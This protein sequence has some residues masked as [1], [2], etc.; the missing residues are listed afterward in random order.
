MSKSK[1]ATETTVSPEKTLAEIQE[2]LKRYG[3]TRV[4]FIDDVEQV[5][6]VFEMRGRRVRFMMP[7]PD[8]ESTK[9]DSTGRYMGEK[10]AGEAH[11]KAVRQR[12]RALLLTI[13][14]KLESVESGIEQFEEAFLA[15]IVL[16][17]GQTMAEWAAPQIEAAYAGNAMPPLLLES[18]R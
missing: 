11:G 2:T 14:A 16:P 10:Q 18:G 4:G 17:S 15:Q 8:P 7:L 3:A 9:R 1:F 12:W 6:I 5:A 13:K